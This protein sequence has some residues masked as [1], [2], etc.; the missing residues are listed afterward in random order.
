MPNLGQLLGLDLEET[1]QLSAN[2]IFAW[3]SPFRCRSTVAV[4][5]ENG[6]AGNV[7]PYYRPGYHGYHEVIRTLIGCPL[8]AERQK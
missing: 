2:A 3:F 5:R 1:Q 8:T 4:A 6:N 7:F